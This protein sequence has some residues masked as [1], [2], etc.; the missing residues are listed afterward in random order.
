MSEKSYN[1]WTNYETWLVNSWLNNC[2]YSQH[3]MRQFAKDSI[4][5]TE[6]YGRD[7]DHAVYECSKMIQNEVEEHMPELDGMFSDLLHSAMQEVNWH[8]IAEHIVDD[9]LTEL[10]VKLSE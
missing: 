6:L 5:C 4:R 8:E 1:G 7:R 3:L 2:E 10:E 9:M